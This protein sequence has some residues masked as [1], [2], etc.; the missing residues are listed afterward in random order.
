MTAALLV[1][2]NYEPNRRI[3]QSVKKGQH[4][5]AGIAEHRIHTLLDE[6][7]DY[8]LSACLARPE[9]SRGKRSRKACFDGCFF[10]G[11]G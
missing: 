11:L 10:R 3:I 7:I 5:T 4:D 9:R 2:G 8:Y 6:R 1:T